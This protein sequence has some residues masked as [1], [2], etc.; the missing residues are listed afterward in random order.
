M[1]LQLEALNRMY[2]A[3]VCETIATSTSEKARLDLS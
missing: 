3:F 2:A 1:G